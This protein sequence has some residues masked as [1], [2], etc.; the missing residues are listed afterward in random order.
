MGG[1]QR[2]GKFGKF[3]HSRRVMSKLFMNDDLLCAS[4]CETGS[5]HI[6]G[7]VVNGTIARAA[8]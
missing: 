2:K 4:S 8:F 6:S 1:G 5:A 7:H 3:N